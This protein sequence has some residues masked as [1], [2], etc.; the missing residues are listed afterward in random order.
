MLRRTPRSTRTDTLF[1]Y[2]TLF[3]S[4]DRGR[5]G[6]RTI[7]RRDAGSDALRGLDRDRER[8]LVILFIAR[9]H[10]RQAQLVTTLLRQR[11]A[12]QAAAVAR[13]EI[14]VFRTHHR[15]EIGRAHV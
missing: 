14:D 5:H 7:V 1:P 13:H 3:R 10:L 2:T 12:D 11:Q 6:T 15:R 4:P 8:G 9:N